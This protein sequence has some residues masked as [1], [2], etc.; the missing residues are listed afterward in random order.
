MSEQ[1]CYKF[2]ARIG[3]THQE[4]QVSE[5]AVPVE[6]QQSAPPPLDGDP[7]AEQPHGAVVPHALLDASFVPIAQGLQGVVLQ[8]TVWNGRGEQRVQ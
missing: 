8:P 1:N 3:S 4:L 2:F 5:M 6:L 7:S